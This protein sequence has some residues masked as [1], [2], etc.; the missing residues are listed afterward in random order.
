GGAF[1]YYE[2]GKPLFQRDGNLNENVGIDKIREYIYYTE[3]HEY[4]TRKQDTNHPYLLDYFNGTGYFFYYKPNAITTLSH[5]TLNIVP[6][7]ADHY[8]I[9]ADVCTISNEQL[10]QMNI[11][12]KKIPRDINRF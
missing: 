1:D 7:K 6:K 9:Y 4:L 3:T 12:F 2:L 10:A 5:D 11:T 8:V